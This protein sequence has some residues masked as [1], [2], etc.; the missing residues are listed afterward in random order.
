MGAVTW[1]TKS[2]IWEAQW[3]EPHPVPGP[4]RDFMFHPLSGLRYSTGQIIPSSPAV[5]GFTK[6]SPSFNTSSGEHRWPRTQ[7]S[8]FLPALPQNKSK[9]SPPIGLLQLLPT[10]IRPWSHIALDFVTGLPPYARN[11]VILTI[12]DCF[13]KVAHFV[14]LSKLPTA[15]LVTNHIFRLH[16]ILWTSSLTVASVPYIH[17]LRRFCCLWRAT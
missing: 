15:Q 11:T 14:A 8:M 6:L 17:H 2:A 16:G 12:V 10:P 3:L 7:G 4:P 13:S 9:S 1:E 5:Q